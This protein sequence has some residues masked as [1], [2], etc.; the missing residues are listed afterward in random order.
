MPF[1]L[2]SKNSVIHIPRVKP[3]LNLL[4][5]CSPG[6]LHP[7]SGVLGG[8]PHPNSP[9]H[10]KSG[11]GSMN[12]PV[13]VCTSFMPRYGHPCWGMRSRAPTDKSPHPRARDVQVSL[14]VLPLAGV[15][16]REQEERMPRVPSGKQGDARSCRI[17]TQP[18]PYPGAQPRA[19]NLA[20]NCL[21]LP[22]GRPV[23]LCPFA[24]A[25]PQVNSGAC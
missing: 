1:L 20:P 3:P 11:Q 7:C 8:P 6:F 25:G 17:H 4:K 23:P 12:P 15:Q 2:P 16:K 9:L 5:R 14:S 21:S 18:L 22:A 24:V 13:Q 10:T 19:P